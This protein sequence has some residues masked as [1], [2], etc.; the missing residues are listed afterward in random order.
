M[1]LFF[2]TEDYPDKYRSTFIFV[3]QLVEEIAAR[4]NECYVIAPHSVTRTKRLSYSKEFN[5]I[6]SGSVEVHRPNYISISNL[7]IGGFSPGLY[8]HK[9]AVLRALK[10]IA[11]TPDAIYCHFWTSAYEVVEYA[12]SKRIPLFVAS[13]ESV[14]DVL[15]NERVRSLLYDYV[16][17]VIC[18]SSKNKEESISL[19]LTKAD[20]CRIIP[21]AVN[22]TL[23]CK[24]DRLT[25]RQEMGFSQ[26]DYIIAYLGWF[27]E[28]KGARRVSE[29]LKRIQGKQVK[30]IF[31]GE[32]PDVPEYAGILFCGSLPHDEI[33]KYLNAA[34][35]FVLPTRKEGCCNAIIEAMACGL[36]IISSDKS[37]NY[38]ILDETNSILCDP[39]NV[40]ALAEA[41]KLLR[42]DLDLRQKLSQGALGRAKKLSI[43]NRA[44]TI[45]SFIKANLPKHD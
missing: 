28:R 20:I 29:A 44:A 22:L 26:S 3:K 36:P 23:F 38:D 17:G 8:L 43:A 27:N 6:R 18:V 14:I 34:D 9:R 35:V 11:H 39:D 16:S 2:I 10:K 45:E 4:G 5:K 19:K 31:I 24:L 7:N 12:I 42:D 41:I 13:G 21:N 37:F 15:P 1:R 33:P 40:E 25:C 32:G 30:G